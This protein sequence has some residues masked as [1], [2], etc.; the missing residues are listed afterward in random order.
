M[1]FQIQKSLITFFPVVRISQK[2]RQFQK[3]AHQA[4]RMGVQIVSGNLI[5]KLHN[6][7]LINEREIDLSAK[8]TNCLIKLGR[9][10]E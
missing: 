1:P 8:M 2:R 6:L 3:K 5:Y 7:N 10:L 9:A 4:V